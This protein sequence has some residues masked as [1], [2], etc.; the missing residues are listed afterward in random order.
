MSCLRCD[1]FD[2]KLGLSG[3]RN[4]FVVFVEV[5]LVNKFCPFLTFGAILGYLVVSRYFSYYFALF[6]LGFAR[7][8]GLNS[9]WSG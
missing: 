8:L 9:I 2:C 5:I 6:C 3:S 1:V 4:N 7:G